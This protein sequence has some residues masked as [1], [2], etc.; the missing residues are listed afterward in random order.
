MFNDVYYKGS[1]PAIYG[2]AD[3][4]INVQSGGLAETTGY[5]P[6][7]WTGFTGGRVSARVWRRRSG[8]AYNRR[9]SPATLAHRRYREQMT[10]LPGHHRLRSITPT[11]MPRRPTAT[12]SGSI[13]T[14]SGGLAAHARPFVNGQTFNCSGCNS[15]LYI[16]AVD[17]PPTQS[18]V[19]GAGQVGNTFHITV[20]GTIG[21]SG[22]GAITAGCTSGSGGSNCI[23]FDFSINTTNGTFG[24]AAALA[25]CGANNL[26]GNAPNYATGAGVCQDNGIG[27][28]TRGFRIGTTQNM[29]TAVSEHFRPARS[30]MT[31]LISSAA[32]STGAGR[33]PV[34]SSRPRSFSACMA[35][36]IRQ[37]LRR[38]WENGRADRPSPI[39]ATCRLSLAASPRSWAMSAGS[40]SP[41]SNAGSGYLD[42][43]YTGVIASCSTVASGDTL[44]RFDLKVLGGAIVDVYPSA[45]STSLAT[46][47]PGLGIGSACTLTDTNFSTTMK[48]SGAGSGGSIN[49]QLAP[50]RGRRRR[51]HLQYRHERD[52]HVP[53]RQ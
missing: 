31:G 20:N 19:S 48:N 8:A 51:R 3:Y 41:I 53:L 14:V 43:F 38:A 50:A 26:N 34:T 29:Y 35:P 17:A 30:S 40:R 7:M 12:W 15:N 13:A 10:P 33:S 42:G 39:T 49:I 6:H 9:L 46:Q 18:N 32:P 16:V 37:A 4:D 45:T 44:P 23:N 11:P 25:T 36:R 52:G 28:L 27:S 22:S 24:T 21:G 2:G 47:A 1:G 5:H